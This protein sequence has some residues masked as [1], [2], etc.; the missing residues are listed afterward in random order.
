MRTIVLAV[1]VSLLAS[2]QSTGRLFV[3][4]QRETP[5]R[6]WLPVSVNG[7]LTGE[8]RRGAF[9]AVDLSPGRHVIS[10]E[11]GVPLTVDLRVGEDAH[12]RVD[13]NH[14]VNRQ[15]IPA[16]T[17]VPRVRAESEMIFL[18]YI[19]AKKRHSSTVPKA[20][21]RRPVQPTLRTRATP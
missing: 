21:P 18:S 15:P 9:F 2:A 20:D 10:V 6:A 13:W 16:L 3:Y 8:V 7:V 11:S 14:H 1:A 17:L 5:A 12:V 4:A 19:P